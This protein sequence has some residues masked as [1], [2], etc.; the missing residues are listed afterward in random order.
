[1]PYTGKNG[2]GTTAP[3][4]LCIF[5]LAVSTNG[6]ASCPSGY[7]E[8]HKLEA[9]DYDDGDSIPPPY[10]SQAT[11]TK[12]T[13]NGAVPVE[14]FGFVVATDNFEG[15]TIPSL[16]THDRAIVNFD[17]V[18]LGGSELSN[19]AVIF[20][21]KSYTHW[22]RVDAARGELKI[23]LPG[24]SCTTTCDLPRSSYWMTAREDTRDSLDGNVGGFQVSDHDDCVIFENVFDN[25]SGCPAGTSPYCQDSS[26][27]SFS[28]PW[29][30]HRANAMS[31][32]FGETNFGAGHA[33]GIANIS[34]CLRDH[35]GTCEKTNEGEDWYLET[36]EMATPSIFNAQTIQETGIDMTNSP[37]G[38]SEA[39]MS[40]T[41]QHQ[42]YMMELPFE[43]PWFCDF[44][45]RLWLSGAGV[46]TF[47]PNMLAGSSQYPGNTAPTRAPLNSFTWFWADMDPANGGIWYYLDDPANDAFHIFGD[48]IGHVTAT[49]T[50]TLSVGYT[51]YKNGVLDMHYVGS[52][53]TW[54]DWTDEGGAFLTGSD[55]ATGMILTAQESRVT[56]PSG[57]TTFR[58][59]P[60][61]NTTNPNALEDGPSVDESGLDEGQLNGAGLLPGVITGAILG[62]VLIGGYAMRQ[63][64]TTDES[65]EKLMNHRDGEEGKMR[66]DKK[67]K[68]VLDQKKKKKVVKQKQRAPRVVSTASSVITRQAMPQMPEL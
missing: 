9:S 14:F 43:F 45:S 50:A 21:D 6:L 44:N 35:D 16:P 63:K 1:M 10:S 53:G 58:F 36:A 17:A 57:P 28:T 18:L 8:A 11:M 27:V 37:A 15:M 2:R 65:G 42:G 31:F 32:T 38:T 34:I 59:T 7:F 26:L 4:L 68:K 55:E 19:S 25:G 5:L 22:I 48:G 3:F 41:N 56:Q 29:F 13:S 12:F 46:A 67:E 54:T 61:F 51:L 52:S 39:E 24:R 23:R 62:V 30:S 60:N 66:K 20:I 33:W 49:K 64:M 47:S 40:L